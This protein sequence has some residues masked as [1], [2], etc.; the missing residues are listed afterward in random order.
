LKTQDLKAVV[1]A[2]VA[3]GKGDFG[4]NAKTANM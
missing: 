1:V 4:Y 2:K 3:E